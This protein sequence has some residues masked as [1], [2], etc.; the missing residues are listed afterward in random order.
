MTLLYT[1]PSGFRHVTPPSHPEQVA[2]LDAVIRALANLELDR[3]EAPDAEDEDILRCHPLGYLA[4]VA[5]KV[6]EEGWSMLDA[7]TYLSPGSLAA[8]RHAVGGVCAAVDAVL[9]GEDAT[10]FVAMRPP[11]HHAER[12]R[13][14]GF[15]IFNSIAIGAVR[16]LD[17]HGLDRVAVLDFDVH[18]GNGTQDLLWNE[19]RS[20]FASTHQFPLYPGT[21]APSERGAHGQILNLPLQAGS[22]GGPARA[23][24]RQ[25]CD[26]VVEW[27]PQLVLVSAGFDAHEADPLASLA[28]EDGDFTAITRLILDAAATCSA[29]VVSVLEGGYDLAALGR[30]ARAHV[31]VLKETPA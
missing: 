21:G 12:A 19:P 27:Q 31:E 16:A 8:A 9:A 3:R 4:A 11:G 17:H 25:I 29:P 6:P 2:R 7:D 18:H 1:H 13:A 10:A 20:L 14:M 5:R 15:C 24:W 26:R 30:T 28:W 23:A 22:E